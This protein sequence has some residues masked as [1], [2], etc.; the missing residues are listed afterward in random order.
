MKIASCQF[1]QQNNFKLK[2]IEASP[3]I[4]MFMKLIR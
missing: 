3:T 2:T 4:S 1:K